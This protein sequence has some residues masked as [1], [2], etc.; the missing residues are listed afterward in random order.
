MVVRVITHYEKIR[1]TY[2]S[3]PKV[4]NTSIKAALLKAEGI[5]FGDAPHHGDLPVTVLMPNA[6]DWAHR[7]RSFTF[8]FVRNPW[9]RLVSAWA[10]K[11]G[12]NSDVDMTAYG[13]PMGCTFERFVEVAAELDDT[14]AEPHFKS[15]SLNLL[16]D[17]QL[18]PSYI[19]RFETIDH[20]WKVVEAAIAAKSGIGVPTL[21]KHRASERQAYR[22][23]YTPRL[24]MLVERRYETDIRLFGY[25]F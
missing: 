21:A 1:A 3:S 23:Y 9:D 25:R 5:E 6:V 22:I 18:I 10:D 12:E 15:Q 4:A 24:A 16:H 11:C 19:G 8:A 7:R 13:L 14:Y 2:V 17:G 20:D